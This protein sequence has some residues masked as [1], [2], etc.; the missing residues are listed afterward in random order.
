MT[1]IKLDCDR[2]QQWFTNEQRELP[3]RLNRNPY[4]VWVSEIM[5]QQT[6]VLVVIPYFERWMQHFP[7]IQD[8]AEASIEQVIKLWE[9]LGYYSRARNLHAGARYVLQHHAGIIPQSEEELRKIKGLG[10]YTIGA[11]RSFAFHQRSAAVDGNV[12]RVLARYF[13]IKEDIANSK[14]IKEIHQRALALLPEKEPW[15][16]GEALIEL[17][18]T[19]CGRKPQC[20]RCPL[21][22]SCQAYIQGLTEQLPFKSKKVKAQKLYRVA[23]IIIWQDKVLVRQCQ[24]GE[25]MSGLYEFPYFELSASGADVNEIIQRIREQFGFEVSFEKELTKI[26]HSFTRYRVDLEASQFKCI[27]QFHPSLTPH[28]HWLSKKEMHKLAFS[29]GHRRI[30]EGLYEVE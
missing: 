24:P 26:T 18:A 19:I 10:P 16:I 1:S 28:H 20:G 8:L 27:A 7:T 2:L 29:S 17:G 15:V 4:A 9:G 25:I 5:L 3:W 12:L 30:R 13:A 11:I 14:T 21:R 22:I 6:Q 23:A